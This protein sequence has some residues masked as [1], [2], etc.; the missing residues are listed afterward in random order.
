[1][2]LGI[3]K[4]TGLKMSR[5]DIPLHQKAYGLFRIPVGWAPSEKILDF[6]LSVNVKLDLIQHDK[7][8]VQSRKLTPTGLLY[9][10]FQEATEVF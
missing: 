7:H 4:K 5:A 2:A 1:M 9:F 6:I 8:A 3:Y 10:C